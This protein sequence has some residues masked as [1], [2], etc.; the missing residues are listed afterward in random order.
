MSKFIECIRTN[1][2]SKEILEEAEGLKN[3]NSSLNTLT[4]ELDKKIAY[5]YDVQLAKGSTPD[6]AEINAIKKVT[7]EFKTEK[8][9]NQ[10]RRILQAQVNTRNKDFIFSNKDAYG[11]I[12][13]TK[14]ALSLLDS[15]SSNAT[16]NN[17]E[18]R[19]RGYEQTLF[20]MIDGFL[21][22]QGTVFTRKA[23]DPVFLQ[24]I[25][26]A[27]F[28]PNTNN[29][30]ALKQYN[31]LKKMI[32][33]VGDKRH[34][35]GDL[36][37]KEDYK[38]PY[39]FNSDKIKNNMTAF[40]DFM[41]N[42]IDWDNSVDAFG[43]SYNP[44]NLDTVIDN[45]SKNITFVGDYDSGIGG[46]S[47]STRK[48]EFKDADAFIEFQDKFGD[49]FLTSMARYVHESSDGIAKMET[50]GSNPIG[51]INYI[52]G[53]LKEQTDVSGKILSTSEKFK[54]SRDE[55]NIRVFNNMANNSV[56]TGKFLKPEPLGIFIGQARSFLNATVMG[57]SL[58]T[59]IPLDLG[60]AMQYTGIHKTN[61]AR[62]SYNY[63]KMMSGLAPEEYK[64]V[65]KR[66]GFLS[67]NIA[68]SFVGYQR[69][70]GYMANS[71]MFGNLTN[72]V[73]QAN[74]MPTHSNYLR[75]I[76][77][78]E[79]NMS[80]VSKLGG[81]FKEADEFFQG[82]LSKFGFNETDW[83]IYKKAPRLE[84][85]GMEFIAPNDL[86][87]MG[88][89]GQNANIK[90]ASYIE[91]SLQE[92]V[93]E[94][95]LRAR[96]A[97]SFGRKGSVAGEISQTLSSFKNT[98]LTIMFSSMSNIQKKGYAFGEIGSFVAMGAIYTTMGGWIAKQTKEMVKG[99]EPFRVDDMDLWK[100]SFAEYND[101]SIITEALFRGSSY[102]N[103]ITSNPTYD[104]VD[105][106]IKTGMSLFDDKEGWDTQRA[107]EMG[108][109][110]AP[111]A[112]LFYTRQLTQKY[113]FD[114]FK[115]ILDPEKFSKNQRRRARR[116]KKRKGL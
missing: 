61:G 83:N 20:S 99:R 81:S 50:F 40:K 108:K 65:L 116:E 97:L 1:I 96:T 52:N 12:D 44:D 67:D 98:P 49:N 92:V 34:Q 30:A 43:R 80:I 29:T 32:E 78:A 59:N 9:S 27:A 89:E 95:S 91:S 47:R 70:L 36:K 106:S 75:A 4:N 104:F 21:S 22:D 23:K 41:R 5:E 15:Q 2:S 37:V 53:I 74:F 69:N 3:V 71:K 19:K 51:G 85:Q 66:L 64:S 103:S 10:R 82:R 60:K 112:N 18:T 109:T 84:N 107:I 114:K 77:G 90:L 35:F 13:I 31:A 110:L 76:Y 6:Q 56:T 33:F 11:D 7:D 88:Q 39:H 86:I 68:R 38:L 62:V 111:G 17:F 102:G 46:A 8:A 42:K 79:V 24:D 87:K 73:Y 101:F 93:A 16:F 14:N 63:L 100:Q 26:R 94:S 48:L 115:N 113:M 25:V 72:M 58:L 45:I 55:H 105:N 28:N 54:K 57:S